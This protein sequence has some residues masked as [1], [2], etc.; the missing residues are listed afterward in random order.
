[1]KGGKL[2]ELR[3]D[4]TRSINRLGIDA[5]LGTPDW[6][7]AQMLTRSLNAYA[8]TLKIRNRKIHKLAADLAEAFK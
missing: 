8:A 1:M 2:K 7:L 5:S 4:I 6:L 3:K